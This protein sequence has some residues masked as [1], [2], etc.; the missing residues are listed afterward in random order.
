MNK[1]EDPH[2]D[3]M[4]VYQTIIEG[5]DELRSAQV[6]PDLHILNKDT[7]Q[8]GGHCPRAPASGPPSPARFPEMSID[9]RL[10]KDQRQD[11]GGGGKTGKDQLGVPS[12]ITTQ[13]TGPTAFPG[14]RNHSHK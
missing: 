8:R 5:R 11:Q 10:L 6:T 12:I 7:Y 14:L 1:V 13:F 9:H 4:L 2:P 3:V